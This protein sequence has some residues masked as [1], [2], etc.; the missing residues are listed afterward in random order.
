[1]VK[2]KKNYVLIGNIA[3]DRKKILQSM[4]VPVIRNLL[5]IILAVV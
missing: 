4:K 3:R 1:M 2:S 5:L